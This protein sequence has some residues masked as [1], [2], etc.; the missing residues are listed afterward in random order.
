MAIGAAS[1]GADFCTCAVTAWA[2]TPLLSAPNTDHCRANKQPAN[3][4][5][6]ETSR[7]L[8]PPPRT[9]ERHWHSH[10]LQDDRPVHLV[11]V[12]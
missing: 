5:G 9:H 6:L 10:Q 7:T 4:P 11:L 8:Y 2:L 1:P 3:Q 12:V